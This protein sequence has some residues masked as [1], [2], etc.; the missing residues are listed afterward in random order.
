M[1]GRRGSVN[2]RTAGARGVGGYTGGMTSSAR[3]LATLDDWLASAEDLR[4]ELVDG[5]LSPKAAPDFD[6]GDA[7][8]ATAAVLRPAFA[9]RRGG[10]GQPGGWWIA[11]EVDIELG[12]HDGYRPDL[13]GWRRERVP[14]RPTERPVR[15]VP[16][17]VCEI[18]SPSNERRDTLDKFRGYHR[19][20]VPHY[21]ILD[22]R[23][24][25]LTVHRWTREGYLVV[26]RAGAE[27]QVRAEPFDAVEI[28][29]GALLGEED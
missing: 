25:T 21:W 26:L 24:R 17:W 8:S 5:E 3:R 27:E 4:M 13:A 2:R 29:V 18:L 19:A 23:T 11:S 16:D 6:H 1:P 20:G 7:Q 12:P 28:R 15:V 10:D 14:E 22:P 9:R